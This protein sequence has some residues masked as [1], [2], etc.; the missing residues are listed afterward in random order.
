M[1]TVRRPLSVRA[2]PVRTSARSLPG[3]VMDRF[4]DRDSQAMPNAPHDHGAV[5][6][7]IVE[8]NSLRLV[9]ASVPNAVTLPALVL[10]RR[11][12]EAYSAILN[13]LSAS[14]LWYPVRIWNWIPSI[15]AIMPGGI[16][17][18]MVFNAG[19]FSAYQGFYG[20][21]GAF[22]KAIATATGVG[23]DG[24]E[25]IIQVLAA[26][27]PGTPVENPRQICAYRYSER[28]GPMPP[29]FARATLAPEEVSDLPDLFIG[30]T[31]SVCGERSMHVGDVE[32][33]CEET[34]R[35]LA[36][37]IAEGARVRGITRQLPAPVNVEAEL[38]RFDSMRIFFVK[39]EQADAIVN[40]VWP[41][42]DHLDAA[43]LELIR[44]DICRPELLVEIEGTATFP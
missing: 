24:N 13:S 7:N 43:H 29:C 30:G 17:R 33:Q 15:H 40:I 3:W 36:H 14:R 20:H 9:S 11:T 27:Q 28:F 2:I 18:Y 37:L 12:V 22:E 23:H 16:D 34:L 42:V 4:S 38:R 8:T 6:L 32:A 35:N 10:Q 41:Y 21:A 44:T 26:N 25:L 5:R 1:L 31:A 19:R 39:P